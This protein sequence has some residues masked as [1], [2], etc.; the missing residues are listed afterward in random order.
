MKN[1]L[2][3]AITLLLLSPLSFAKNKDSFDHMVDIASFKSKVSGSTWNYKWRNRNYIFT[4]EPDGTIS[5]LKSWSGV[6]WD[7]TQKNEV[8]LK[9]KTDNMY[10]YFN[11]AVTEFQ[12][13]DWNREKAS[14]ELA[15]KNNK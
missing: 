6:T 11:E 14:G 4:F 7:I 13:V 8:I 12:T 5:K 10:L 2:T 1:R 3:I 9:A 15:F